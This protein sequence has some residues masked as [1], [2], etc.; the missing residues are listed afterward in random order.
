LAGVSGKPA[1]WP[2]IDL[3]VTGSVQWP[4]VYVEVTRAYQNVQYWLVVS[5]ATSVKINLLMTRKKLVMKVITN[6]TEVSVF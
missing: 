2:N 5:T 3:S 1:A 6:M 4:E